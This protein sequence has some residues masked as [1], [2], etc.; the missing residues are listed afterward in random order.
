MRFSNAT[1]PFPADH[2]LMFTFQK[3]AADDKTEYLEMTTVQHHTHNNYRDHM[4]LRQQSH[5]EDHGK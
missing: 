5:R 1:P 3:I 4:E 2:V